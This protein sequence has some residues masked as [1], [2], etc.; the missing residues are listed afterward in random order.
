MAAGK[1]LKYGVC[2]FVGSPSKPMPVDVDVVACFP[3]VPQGKHGK[4]LQ[5]LKGR[6]LGS[7]CLDGQNHKCVHMTEAIART[8]QCAFATCRSNMP[9]PRLAF[10][11]TVS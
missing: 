8:K 1:T 6:K 10:C 4:G 5:W 11:A 9:S 7:H 2:S 3:S